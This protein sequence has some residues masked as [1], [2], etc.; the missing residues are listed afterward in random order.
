MRLFL[1]IDIPSETK[2]SISDQLN[3]LKDAYPD[4]SWT[5]KE[6]YHVTVHFFG[7]VVHEEKLKK[8]LHNLLFDCRSFYLYPRKINLFLRKNITFYVDFL[9]S[10][11]LESIQEKC[12]QEFAPISEEQRE[13]IPH[14]T[15]GHYRIPSK[16][17]YFLLK[18]RLE[19][20]SIDGEFAVNSLVLY[21]S[22]L[23]DGAPYYKVIESFPLINDTP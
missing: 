12:N 19:K 15:V 17:Q 23:N 3:E 20:T 21:E 8:R 5:D 11:D 2:S 14:I 7:E 16:Q 4:C 13:F 18:K 6:T 1:A 22:N 10:K 9:R